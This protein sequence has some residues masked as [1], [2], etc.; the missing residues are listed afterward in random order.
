MASIQPSQMGTPICF[1]PKPHG[2]CIFPK[3]LKD[4]FVAEILLFV[5]FGGGEDMGD[6]VAS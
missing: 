1:T 5:V 2:F 4:A 3:D 6:C